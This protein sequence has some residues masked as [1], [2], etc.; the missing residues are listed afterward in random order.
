MRIYC[1]IMQKRKGFDTELHTYSYDSL[2]RGFMRVSLSS[3][4]VLGVVG[5]AVAVVSGQKD[6]RTP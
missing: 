4:S 6:R 2:S 3:S 1:I 5:L